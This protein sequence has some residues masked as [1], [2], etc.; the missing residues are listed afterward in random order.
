MSVSSFPL[1]DD[2]YSDKVVSFPSDGIS[3][4]FISGKGETF[5]TAHKSEA[6]RV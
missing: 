2:T 5:D 3:S 4:D 1:Q 6:T